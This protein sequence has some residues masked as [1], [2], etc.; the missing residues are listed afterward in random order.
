MSGHTYE[1][2][3]ISSLKA[4][5]KFLARM[6]SM[7]IAMASNYKSLLDESLRLLR[8]HTSDNETSAFLAKCSLPPHEEGD[9]SDQAYY[10]HD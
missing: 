5:K 2:K 7:Y 3:I 8:K 9:D 6:L 10:R 4:D 1:D